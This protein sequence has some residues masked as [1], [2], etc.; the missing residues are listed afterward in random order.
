MC[1]E[2]RR[3]VD[4][5]IGAARLI[6]VPTPIGNLGDITL[7]AVEVLRGADRILAEDTRRTGVLLSHL[8]IDRSKLHRLDANATERDLERALRWLLAGDVLAVVTDAGTPCVS[9]PGH[10]L[11]CR[12]V[13]AGVQV[14]ALPGASAVTAAVALSGLVQGGFS[15]VGFVPRGQTERMDFIEKLSC[16]AEPCVCFESPNRLAETLRAMADAMPERPI[17]IAREL[18]KLHEEVIRGV[19]RDVA[20]LEREWV[21]EVTVVLGPWA[22]R[23]EEA[24]SDTQVDAR[25][26][27]ELGRGVHTRTVAAKVA[28]WSGRSRRDVYAR[29]VE[30]LE[31]VRKRKD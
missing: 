29:V 3:E 9:D 1:A 4:L 24:V 2:S 14:T 5:G 27:D 6:L 22:G 15:F 8:G 11:V 30:R 17:V 23:I 7:R 10:A 12:A 28:A 16:M 19:V 26:D 20:L 25:I 31:M 18:T 13:D 21:G